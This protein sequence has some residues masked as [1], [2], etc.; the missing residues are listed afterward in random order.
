MASKMDVLPALSGFQVYWSIP[1]ASYTLTSNYM[2]IIALSIQLLITWHDCIYTHNNNYYY[3]FT[4]FYKK[5]SP[6]G[7]FSNKYRCPRLKYTLCFIVLPVSIIIIIVHIMYIYI[8]IAGYLSAWLCWF[9]IMEIKIN[10]LILLPYWSTYLFMVFY[11]CSLSNKHLPPAC[12]VTLLCI[13]LASSY[14]CRQSN[15]H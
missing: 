15:S 8:C 14:A 13:C 7:Q 3:Y 2:Y 1:K 11:C 6:W 5:N 12:W 10:Q 4:E 9:V